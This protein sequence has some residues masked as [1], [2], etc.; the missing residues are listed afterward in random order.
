MYIKFIYDEHLMV[1]FYDLNL[2]HTI[3]NTIKQTNHYFMDLLKRF[4]NKGDE[5]LN[6]STEDLTS[7]MKIYFTKD[8][9]TN[10]LNDNPK[11]EG[12]IKRKN[13]I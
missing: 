10:I 13:K 11:N 8:E 12:L 4:N 3:E 1:K 6:Y 5:L 7:L 2:E 9:L